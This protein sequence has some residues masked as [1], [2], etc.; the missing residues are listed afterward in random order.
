VEVTVVEQRKQPRHELARQALGK[1][2]LLTPAA[3]YP[4]TAIRDISSSGI[5]LF[6]DA[7]LTERLDV[8]VEY[9]EPTLKL[10]MQ[11]RVAWCAEQAL[12]AEAIKGADRY[13]LGIELF[14][15][16]LFMSMAGL[17]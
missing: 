10:E 17:Y 3:A 8:V 1:F 9:T 4:I 5:R 7:R 13:V 2:R 6:L 12:G 14:S 16:F 11:G 15:P